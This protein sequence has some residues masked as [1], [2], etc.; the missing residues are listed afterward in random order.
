M[1]LSVAI[2]AWQV[3][4]DSSSS[5]PMF[6]RQCHKTRKQAHRYRPPSSTG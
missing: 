1:H 2:A 5:Q 6:T 3:E 4:R